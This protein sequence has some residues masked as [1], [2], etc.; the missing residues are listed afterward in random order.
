MNS[1]SWKNIDLLLVSLFSLVLVLENFRFV[2]AAHRNAI[3][4][5]ELLRNLGVLAYFGHDVMT[6]WGIYLACRIM[7][8]AVFPSVI[9]SFAFSIVGAQR[10]AKIFAKSK[11]ISAA[12][13]VP[14]TPFGK[15]VWKFDAN[16]QWI[17]AHETGKGALI[18]IVIGNFLLIFAGF[19]KKDYVLG[20]SQL[21]V[22]LGNGALASASAQN[23]YLISNLF[24]I[25]W[26]ASILIA[27]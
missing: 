8:F 11:E 2:I 12:T 16:L 10:F 13:N 22:F 7:N 24:E 20:I 17:P 9:V 27:L 18:P 5:P 19:Y 26:L 14:S 4:I 25:V 23:R 3:S 6:P 1:T 21:I 15:Y